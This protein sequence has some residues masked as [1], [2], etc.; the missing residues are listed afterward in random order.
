[1]QLRFM[2][3]PVVGM[4]NIGQCAACK[5]SVS[6]AYPSVSIAYPIVLLLTLVCRLLTLLLRNATSLYG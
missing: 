5:S 2:G 6:I 4:F 3:K 1:M